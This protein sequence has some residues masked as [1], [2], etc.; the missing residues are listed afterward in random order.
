MT[1]RIIPVGELRTN[2]YIY[3]EPTSQDAM[4][5][6]PGADPHKILSVI[7][8]Q[9]LHVKYIINTHGHYD[10]IEANRDVKAATGALIYMHPLDKPMM[11]LFQAWTTLPPLEPDE[12]LTDQQTFLLGKEIFTVWHTPGHSPGGIS[13]LGNDCVFTGDTL[14]AGDIGRYD[15]LGS[16]LK[17]LKA[18]LTR[19]MT[20]PDACRVYPG[21]GISTTIGAE[22]RKR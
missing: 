3:S 18:S 7:N 15:L 11:H 13:L 17:E 19:L 21:H 14:F 4:I 5:I 8:K 20:L 6:D 2:C 22:R 1:L 10:H 12:A 16:S 9:K